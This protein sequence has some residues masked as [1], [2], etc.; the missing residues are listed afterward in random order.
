L[1]DLPLHVSVLKHEL[2]SLRGGRTPGVQAIKTTSQATGIHIDR[3]STIGETLKPRRLID[4]DE[5]Q[6]DRR[7]QAR[8]RCGGLLEQGIAR[9]LAEYR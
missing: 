1:T 7:R 2:L 8:N 3:P 4:L 9:G 5:R 6:V